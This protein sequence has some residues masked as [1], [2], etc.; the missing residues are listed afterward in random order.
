[1]LQKKKKIWEVDAHFGASGEHI[2]H[3]V[4]ANDLGRTA[5]EYY[6]TVINLNRERRQR[7]KE[8]PDF[9]RLMA[10]NPGILGPDFPPLQMNGLP[11]GLRSEASVR[12]IV[13]KEPKQV[14]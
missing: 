5:I 8:F 7:L 4:T 11:K 6:R 12:V 13:A 2:L 14:D 1:M 9:V 10:T 3:I